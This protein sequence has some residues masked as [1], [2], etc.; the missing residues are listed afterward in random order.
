[1][2]RTRLA[3]LTFVVVFLAIMLVGFV[4]GAFL[5][6]AV[7]Q[8]YVLL[9]L[10]SDQRRAEV[11]AR[12]IEQYLRSGATPE[13]AVE[14]FQF[15][16]EGTPADRMGYVCLLDESGQV[17]AHPDGE[18]VGKSLAHARFQ[19][20][21]GEDL[22]LEEALRRGVW[23]AG[24]LRTGSPE[25]FEVVFA[26]PV[27]GTAW[28]ASA[29][30]PTE[31]I[32]QQLRALGHQLRWSAALLGA[33][34][35]LA[36]SVL[37]RLIARGYESRIEEANQIL[38]VRVQ[39][40]T[41]E[42]SRALEDL[43][44]AHDRLVKGEKMTLLGQL[45]SGITHE[46]RTPLSSLLTG[47]HLL[48][49]RKGDPAEVESVVQQ[50]EL[51]ASRLSSIVTNMLAFAREAKP[52]RRSEDL[53]RI[54]ASAIDLI[55]SEL[56][57]DGIR[58]QQELAPDLPALFLDAQ[59]IQQ[60]VLN[61]LNNARQALAESG[62]REK[63]LDVR[64]RREGDVVLLEVEDNGPGIPEAARSR[65]FEPFFTT[66]TSGTGLGLSL[67]RRFVEAQGAAIELV[68]SKAGACFRVS[69]PVTVRADSPVRPASVAG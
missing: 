39:Q 16:V 13:E 8:R 43:R 45:M 27:E 44:V 63:R 41:A 51:A 18:Q 20:A 22:R 17:V 31:W 49:R 1:V 21:F 23:L 36:A 58:L 48:R 10:D 61:L 12:L 29:H 5:L 38:E 55:D 34:M 54:C 62:A 2:K 3:I 66:K 67:C 56:N 24:L 69:F 42:L 4:G 19:S 30:I 68:P 46:I 15:V 65:I 50:M 9:H 40:R 26:I 64:T 14:R 33:V 60:V 59:Q 35:A 25:R 37:A 52:T 7:E 6:D 32:T 53:N 47:C 11:A 57:H 28:F